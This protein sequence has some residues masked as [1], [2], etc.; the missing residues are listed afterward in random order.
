MALLSRAIK[1]DEMHLLL[2]GV[3]DYRVKG[4]DDMEDP[5]DRIAL[6]NHYITPYQLI[7]FRGNRLGTAIRRGLDQL[8]EY[9]PDKGLAL[10]S[11]SGT[12]ID[13][14]YRKKEKR[15]CFKLPIEGLNSSIAKT[16][17]E[18][19]ENLIKDIRWA[20]APTYSKCGLW[21]PICT[22]LQRVRDQF[23]G[24]DFVSLLA[25]TELAQ[26]EKLFCVKDLNQL[27]R[28]FFS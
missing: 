11:L 21:F 13:Y 18:Q 28:D 3:G 23:H 1:R 27:H 14:Y 12:L 20:G 22:S 19:K 16:L 8:L 9:E 4:L 10:Y 5:Q 7:P 6:W 17:L 24:A 2:M 26:G 15:I 25:D